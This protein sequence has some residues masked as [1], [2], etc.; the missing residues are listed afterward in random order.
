M[1]QKVEYK[2]KD[3]IRK[4]DFSLKIL[5]NILNKL[6]N[7]SVLKARKFVSILDYDLLNK[8]GRKGIEEDDP[9][10]MPDLISTKH[11]FLWGMGM[12]NDNSEEIRDD[13]KRIQDWL[14]ITKYLDCKFYG[15]LRKNTKAK[16]VRMMGDNVISSYQD[17]DDIEDDVENDDIWKKGEDWE[18]WLLTNSGV[19]EVY[20]R[21]GGI[22][23]E[24]L[25]KYSVLNESEDGEFWVEGFDEG[26][27]YGVFGDKTLEAY[28]EWLEN[29]TKQS[30]LAEE[31]SET[32]YK[33]Q[34][35]ERLPE[36]ANKLGIGEWYDL[37]E[38]NNDILDNPDLPPTG[39]TIKIPE[40]D[41]NK[42]A[43]EMLKERVINPEEVLQEAKVSFIYPF[44][45]FS[46]IL[47]NFN[48]MPIEVESGTPFL[49]TTEED[50]KIILGNIG[51]RARIS[52]DILKGLHIFI[53]VNNIKY[54]F[55]GGS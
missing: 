37:Y 42:K 46:I 26:E 18:Y 31:A 17:V 6:E 22:I 24:Y 10:N 4:K 23:G 48:G 3:F 12:K 27:E 49:I 36:I 29:Y 15:W 38:Y 7:D 30:P 47:C 28:I 35:G 16:N 55:K 20:L 41:D 40:F 5:A 9:D 14:I 52:L 1:A 34:E 32:K 33:I 11:L 25:S 2:V 8:L 51:A 43:K 19:K 39:I 21:D 44:D 54:G 53:Y 13:V 50:E 45:K